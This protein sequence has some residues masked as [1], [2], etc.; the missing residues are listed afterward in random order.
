MSWRKEMIW[1]LPWLSQVSIESLCITQTGYLQQFQL[2]QADATA[3]L[4]SKYA[5][6]SIII[7]HQCYSCPRTTHLDNWTNKN[8]NLPK[9]RNRN[10]TP[11]NSFVMV[12]PKIKKK[13]GRE[14]GR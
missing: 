7:T 10:G 3:G 5:L 4:P 6:S 12:T 2:V 13:L 11:Y 14:W 8:S 1:L 9:N